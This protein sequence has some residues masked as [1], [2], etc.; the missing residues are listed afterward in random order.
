[1]F[2]L[3]LALGNAAGQVIIMR[4]DFLLSVCLGMLVAA[5]TAPDLPN[6]PVS[7][8]APYRNLPDPGPAKTIEPGVPVKLS[9]HQLHAVVN[10]VTKW[11]K[12]PASVSFAGI[13]GAKN[14]HG[15][16]TVCG[17]VSGRNSA[18]VAISKSPFVGALMGPP[19]APEF[20]VVEI[21]S[22]AEQRTTVDGLC[23]QSGISR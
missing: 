5:C 20:V 23:Q 7:L 2:A 8:Q 18:G 14:R 12:D 11:M 3:D 9:Q 1:V 15:V 13:K 6:R 21:G 4:D 19:N 22:T 16:I 17:D 10:G